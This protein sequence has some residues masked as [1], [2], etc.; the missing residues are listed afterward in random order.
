MAFSFCGTI[1]MV[2][3]LFTGDKLL[4]VC[5]PFIIIIIIIIK[6]LC[7]YLDY[8]VFLACECDCEDGALFYL[9]QAEIFILHQARGCSSLSQSIALLAKTLKMK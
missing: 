1:V 6:H 3:Q 4:N 9:V 8:V 5:L 2:E 7:Q